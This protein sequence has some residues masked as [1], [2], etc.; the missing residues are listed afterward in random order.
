MQSRLVGFAHMD[1]YE[2]YHNDRLHAV[3]IGI[4]AY[5]ADMPQGELEDKGCHGE[6]N[7]YLASLAQCGYCQPTA[8]TNKKDNRY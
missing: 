6:L 4:L 3:D 8:L 2:L 5:V 7:D 1:V